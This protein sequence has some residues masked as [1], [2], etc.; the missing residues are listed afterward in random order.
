MSG[1]MVS[2]LAISLVGKIGQGRSPLDN[3]QRDETVAYGREQPSIS[4][5]LAASYDIGP[6]P[7]LAPRSASQPSPPAFAAH[8]YRSE[9]IR[10]VDR[11]VFGPEAPVDRT[12]GIPTSVD[13]LA[14][15]E[16]HN[17]LR[18]GNERP[19]LIDRR[20]GPPH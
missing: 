16:R 11:P 2:R 17:P 10:Q 18:V 6:R 1:K 20:H 8:L 12:S 14:P 4:R 13:M 15:G 9:E 19:E 7:M 3:S 5:S